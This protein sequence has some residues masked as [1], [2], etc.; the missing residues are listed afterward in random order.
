[1]PNENPHKLSTVLPSS[2]QLEPGGNIEM[3][4]SVLLSLPS[5]TPSLAVEVL[6]QGVTFHRIIVQ[7]D[8]RTHDVVIGPEVPEEHSTQKYVGTIIGRYANRVPVGKH[9]VERKGIKAEFEAQ[10][11]ESPRVSLHGGPTGFDLLPWKVLS[12]EEKPTLFSQAEIAHLPKSGSGSSFAFFQ[13]ESPDRDQGYPGKLLVE[14]LVAV[15][16]PGQQE[17][18]YSESP[19]DAVGKEY[20]LGSIVYVY[21]AKVDKGVTPINLTNHWG[22]NLDASLKEGEESLSVKDHSLLLKADHIAQRDADSLCTALVPA[23]TE[24]VHNGK[25]IGENS[26]P[27]GYD[28]F[29]LF[30]EKPIPIPRRVELSSFNDNFDLLGDLLRPSNGPN[31]SRGARTE[32]FAE[33]A[34]EKSGIKLVFDTNQTGMMFYTNI[35]ASPAK[36]ARKKIH[37]G[38]GTKDH[39]D[40]YPEWAAAFLEFH[41]PLHAFLDPAKK[42]KDDTLLTSD[43][44]YNNY[45]RLD[46][47][48]KEVRRK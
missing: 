4:D 15:I 6:P 38:S 39:G 22:F 44:L 34:S 48:F 32:P 28:D 30:E 19:G 5:L 42:D 2:S 23:P 36:G 17:R 31:A 13:L 33:L 45:V 25:K 41:E 43:E 10:P 26:P 20:D 12:A 7:A 1:M 21:R 35:G 47:R 18:K 9:T 3:A 46:V 11:N 37:G 16:E 27:S 24:H 14:A 29:Y 8:G 40:G